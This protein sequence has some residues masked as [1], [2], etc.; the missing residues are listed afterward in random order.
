MRQGGPEKLIGD[1]R[2]SLRERVNT[3][4]LFGLEEPREL[5]K[6]FVDLTI[7]EDYRRPRLHAEFLGMMDSGMRQQRS[8]FSGDETEPGREKEKRTVRPDELLTRRTRAV[9]TGAPGCGK[10][11]LLRYLTFQALKE[12]KRLPLFLELKTVGKDDFEKAHNLADLL[13]EKAI[14]G[15][16]RLDD[17]QR[18]K[19][20]DYF[21]ARLDAGEAAVFLDGLDE[22]SR[23]AF[24]DLCNEVNEFVRSTHRDN[25]LMI[26]TRP[27]ALR[28]QFDGV[29]QMEIAPLDQ[30]QVEQFI[31]HYYRDDAITARLLQEIRRRREMGNLARAPMLLGAMI[32]LYRNRNQ[33]I[34]DRLE[35]YRQIVLHLAVRLDEEK[36]VSRV[37]QFQLVD[38]DGSLKIYFLKELACERLLIDEVKPDGETGEAARVVFTGEMIVEKAKLFLERT[39][40]SE[41]SPYLLAADVKATPLL[42]EVGADVYAFSH[43]TIQEYLAASALA[44]RKDYR[45]IFCRTYFNTTIVE[46][47]VLPMTLG[48][49]SNAAELYTLLDQLPESLNFASLRLRARGLGYGANAGREHLVSLTERLLEFISGRN[50]EE[51][52]YT[53]VVVRAFSHAARLH[54]NFIIPRVASLLNHQDSDVR[55]S[56][57]DAFGQI[58]SERA[59]DALLSALNDQD[60][61][62]R[63]RAASA[64][65]KIKDDALRGGLYLALSGERVFARIK[66]VRTVGYYADSRELL[67]QLSRLAT[68]DTVEEVR[69]AASEARER[70]LRKLRLLV[71]QTPDAAQE[72]KRAG[73][74]KPKRAP[75][76][77][78]S[79]DKRIKAAHSKR[80]SLIREKYHEAIDEEDT[81][82]KGRALEEL[83]AALIA[84]IEGF[85]E[86]GRD[87]H[88]ETEEIDIIF[89]NESRDPFW[90]KQGAMILVE[91][92]NWKSQR[93]GKNE[94]VVFREKMRNRVSQC[95]LGFLVCTEEFADTVD[96]EM[97]RGSSGNLLVVPINGERLRELVESSDRNALLKRFTTDASLK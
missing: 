30:R 68:D 17:A 31:E 54:S 86:S 55:R 81:H 38:P 61:D 77:T 44:R 4:R 41:I 42:R 2:A 13:F 71:I 27:Y 19:L 97:L 46:M 66:A 45:E 25:L 1:Y 72:P 69:A 28:S 23:E 52:T 11:T 50:E 84:S 56:A 87:V 75:T 29:E 14:C 64:L 78:R 90:E 89:R 8:L 67:D 73:K 88:T 10:T 51:A 6:V 60:H 34:E 91:C 79:N 70:F 59:V 47:E 16:S 92:K 94:F 26:S 20:K 95:R 83:L 96:K 22:L 36:G 74:R 33:I 35:L 12:N 58:G 82:K 63:R 21:L 62:V 76:S 65:G 3:V 53:W 57:A 40:R 15:Q 24:D 48:L 93:V 7:I 9:V 39:N 43:L 18:R 85:I 80:E 49:M 32:A 37:R 5:E